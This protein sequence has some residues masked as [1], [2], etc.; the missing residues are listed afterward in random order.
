MVDLTAFHGAFGD[1]QTLALDADFDRMV[2]CSYGP[3]GEVESYKVIVGYTVL[4]YD[5]LLHIIDVQDVEDE[6]FDINSLIQKY[7]VE[8]C[9]LKNFIGDYGAEVHPDF[10]FNS[11]QNGEIEFD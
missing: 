4:P 6:N 11:Y 1:F 2:F 3:T 7:G 9:F 10:Q 5:I 8:L